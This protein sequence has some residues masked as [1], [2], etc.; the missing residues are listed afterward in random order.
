MR[1]GFTDSVDGIATCVCVEDICV[2]CLE[3]DG[4]GWLYTCSGCSE[5]HVRIH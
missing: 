2:S 3:G 4:D 5:Q 1:I